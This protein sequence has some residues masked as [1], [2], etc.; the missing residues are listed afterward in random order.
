M[1]LA[2]TRGIDQLLRLDF[3]QSNSEIDLKRHESSVVSA[4]DMIDALEIM[5]TLFRDTSSMLGKPMYKGERE[6][7]F[8]HDL[9]TYIEAVFLVGEDAK[10][11]ALLRRKHRS[12]VVLMLNPLVEQF[13]RSTHEEMLERY[14]TAIDEAILHIN[15]NERDASAD[16]AFVVK[17]VIQKAVERKNRV[18]ATVDGILRLRR[19][20]KKKTAKKK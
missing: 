18:Q 15:N 17:R 13:H 10:Q 1:S 4:I 2:V 19:R 14:N 6:F 7:D 8:I 16:D 3:P 5:R 9:K 12:M 11:C 20:K